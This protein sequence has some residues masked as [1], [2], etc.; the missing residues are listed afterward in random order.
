MKFYWNK[1]C[2]N[3]RRRFKSHRTCSDYWLDAL[4]QAPTQASSRCSSYQRRLGTECE[5]SRQAWQVT[6]HPKSLRTT[7]VP[8]RLRQTD[9][10]WLIIA[11]CL[12]TT[13]LRVTLGKLSAPRPPI[14][15]TVPSFYNWDVGTVL[16]VRNLIWDK[17]D[18]NW[19]GRFRNSSK[20]VSN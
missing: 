1:E 10:S 17:V 3:A 9:D 12:C 4:F 19:V 16:E 6:S 11:F 18:S 5:L 13:L 2:F 14:S 8:L 20:P 7:F 15:L